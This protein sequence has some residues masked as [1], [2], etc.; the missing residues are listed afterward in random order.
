MRALIASNGHGLLPFAWRLRREEVDTEVL[1]FKDKYE[2]AWEG[3]PIE[4]I[5][6]GKDKSKHTLKLLAEMAN[7]GDMVVLTDSSR[8]LKIFASAK[9]VF[10]RLLTQGEGKGA[11]ALGAWFNGESFVLEHLL[12]NDWGLWPGGL[13][14]NVLGGMVLVNR[15]TALHSQLK[16]LEDQLKSANFKGLISAQV[17]VAPSGQFTL[18]QVEFGWPNL[19]SEAF[20]SDISSLSDLLSLNGDVYLGCKYVVTLPVTTP[21]YPLSGRSQVESATI[22]GLDPEDTKSIF[23]HDFK[24]NG[25]SEILSAGLDGYLCVVRGSGNNLTMARQRALAIAAKIQVPEKQ[26]RLD[27]GARADFVLGMLEEGGVLH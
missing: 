17:L 18:G 7:D 23:F 10:P 6:R 5:V 16:P 3:M 21:P 14:P 1:V 19:H 25:H 12:L 11:F 26:V 13:G 15:S 2:A 8:G 24:T 27:V 22:G 20:L 9:D 4:K